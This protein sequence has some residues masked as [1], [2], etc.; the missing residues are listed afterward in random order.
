MDLAGVLLAEADRL[1][2]AGG[3]E[4][5]VAL[6]LQSAAGQTPDGLLVLD[7]ENRLGP[8]GQSR[9]HRRT[10]GPFSGASSTR[11]R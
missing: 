1:A 8:P 10:R 4:D 6:S 2:G 11:G 5:R 7:D 3:G 9:G